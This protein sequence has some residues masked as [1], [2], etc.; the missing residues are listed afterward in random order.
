MSKINLKLAKGRFEH[1]QYIADQKPAFSLHWNDN[2]TKIG[3]EYCQKVLHLTPK[4]RLIFDDFIHNEMNRCNLLVNPNNGYRFTNK[5]IEDKYEL[6]PRRRREIMLELKN[7]GF[8][9][10]FI[11]QE[12]RTYIIN[13]MIAS[14]AT[15]IAQEYLQM[16]SEYKVITEG[17]KV[18]EMYHLFSMSKDEQ[19]KI[20]E[21]YNNINYDNLDGGM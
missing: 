12:N 21:E 13:P 9:A 6:T 1:G 18:S 4:A 3:K 20:T 2:F 15:D 10:E 17:K 16:F 5:D 14:K 11:F 19:D 8:I 7:G